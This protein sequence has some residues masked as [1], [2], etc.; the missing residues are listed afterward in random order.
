MMHTRVFPIAATAVLA[1]CLSPLGGCRVT[2][3]STAEA[4]GDLADYNARLAEAERLA[5]EA[6]KAMNAGDDDRAISLYRA[7][8]DASGDFPDVWN[9]LGLLLLKRGDLGPA[10]SAF[11]RAAELD[12]TDP[13]AY[14][15]MGVTNL[16]AQW[17]E[18]AIEDF[19]KALDI[20]PNYLPALRGAI[21][22]A[23]LL[24]RAEYEDLDRVK[25]ALLAERDE[26]WRAFFERQRYLIQSRLNSA[27]RRNDNSP[28]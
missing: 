9:N 3:D 8:I 17:A 20:S 4:R 5:G 6:Q 7:S 21:Q 10:R 15:N 1:A 22:A 26:R 12:P 23:D 2:P 18:D 19:K 27:K 13:R 11:A 25:R 28:D 24:G 16:R 14:Y